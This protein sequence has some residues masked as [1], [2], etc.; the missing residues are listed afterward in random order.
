MNVSRLLLAAAGQA[1]YTLRIQ[2]RSSWSPKA[3]FALQELTHEKSSSERGPTKARASGAVVHGPSV[4]FARAVG[5]CR[6]IS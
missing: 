5:N 3:A 1:I 2:G 6:T 4:L